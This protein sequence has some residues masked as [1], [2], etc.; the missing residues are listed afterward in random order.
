[1]R[2][3]DDLITQRISLGRRDVVVVKQPSVEQF[4]FFELDEWELLSE[5][6]NANHR[7]DFVDEDSEEEMEVFFRAAAE[8]GLI[9]GHPSSVAPAA[10]PKPMWYTNPFVI[11]VPGFDPSELLS[12]MMLP[13]DRVGRSLL[14]LLAITIIL[15][16]ALVAIMNLSALAAD[17]TQAAARI[18][19]SPNQ[20]WL[21]FLIAVAILK[22]GH[23]FAHG[24]A[25]HWRGGRCREMGLL[26]LFGVPCLYCDVSDT[27][28]MPKR[29]HRILV[30]AAGMLAEFLIASIALLIWSV[31]YQGLIHDLMSML[32]VV[33][34]VSTLLINANPLLRYD[35]Y[36]ILSDWIGIPN[37][38]SES[39]V[40]LRDLLNRGGEQPRQFGLAAYAVASGVYRVFVIGLIVWLVSAWILK[41]FGAGLAIPV[42]IWIGWN[43]FRRWISVEVASA[44]PRIAFGLAAVLAAFVLWMP[45]PS[46]TRVGGLIRP[47]EE[48]PVYTPMSGVLKLTARSIEVVNW[49]QQLAMMAA[50][51]EA[52]EMETALQSREIERLADPT[53]S[54]TLPL[55]R[56]RLITAKKKAEILASQVAETKKTIPPGNQLYEPPRVREDRLSQTRRGDQRALWRGTPAN[57]ANSKLF[58][59]KGLLLG[60]LGDSNERVVSAYVP[61]QQIDFIRIGAAV[62]I[63]IGSCPQGTVEGRVVEIASDPVNELPPEILASG[64]VRP[65]PNTNSNA[66]PENTHYEVGIEVT[67]AIALPAR[68]VTPVRIAMPAESLWNRLLR[69]WRSTSTL[70]I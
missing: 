20:G 61:D 66:K 18:W 36:F 34:S 12:S 58:V 69:S 67:S 43:L 5:P 70:S 10:S 26:L 57:H 29:R 65:T 24:L 16:A 33:A 1:M 23:E 55:W 62:T 45:I 60:R 30:S 63:A 21:L 22:V 37:L 9:V 64:W 38:G 13:I 50:E 15:F 3:A 49:Q 44:T 6:G 46:S 28:L 32:V 8:Q 39:N 48:R 4:F 53:I 27:W 31:T 41:S 56:Q 19:M 59:E 17:A 68:L 25:C 11:R 52:D 2:L 47:A 54:L 42:A 40:A 35:G 7:S 14:K 51:G